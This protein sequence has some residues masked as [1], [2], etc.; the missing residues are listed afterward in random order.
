MVAV[1]RGLTRGLCT[2]F[3]FSSG[4]DDER[5]SEPVNE[6]PETMPFLTRRLWGGVVVSD[7]A[8]E[9]R[10]SSSERLP[11]TVSHYHPCDKIACPLGFMSLRLQPISSR[12]R[13]AHMTAAAYGNISSRCFFV[14]LHR[15]ALCSTLLVAEKLKNSPKG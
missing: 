10:I 13:E 5:Q 12:T 3:I 15:S 7:V 9:G 4:A 6:V 14:L 2:W 11:T 8:I 1:L